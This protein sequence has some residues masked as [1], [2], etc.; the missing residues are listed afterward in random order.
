[1]K[2]VLKG[3]H[4]CGGDLFP[5]GEDRDGRTLYC[6]QCGLNVRVAER[7]RHLSV[8]TGPRAA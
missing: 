4:R 3:C 2:M 6:L 7:P 8:A 5:D 1:M